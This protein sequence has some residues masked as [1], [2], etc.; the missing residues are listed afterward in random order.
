M[1][2]SID[3]STSN[4]YEGTTCLINKLGI[5]DE[6]K[7][8]EFEG[9]VTFAKASELELNPISDTFDV[10]HYK[11]IHKYLFEDIY[12]WAGEYRT[13]NISKKGTKFAS[14]DQISDLMNACFMRLK[15]N[16]YFQNKSFDE[17][18]DN[19]VDFYCVTN[20]I[21]PFREGNGRTQRLFISQLIRFNNYDIDFSSIDKD[22]LMIA[23]IHAANGIVDYLKDIFYNN[24]K[25][26][27]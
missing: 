20:M 23:T 8:K 22:E 27:K 5:T 26:S 4:C 12:D 10:E 13:V 15:D 25:K 3:S 6:N 17:F 9:A 18:I 14:A 7:L 19:I 24:I 16:D 21:H 2:Y 1:S 11:L